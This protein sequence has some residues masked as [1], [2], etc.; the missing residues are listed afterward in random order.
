MYII[1]L[2]YVWGC[3]A[4]HWVKLLEGTNHFVQPIFLVKPHSYS[5]T[6]TSPLRLPMFTSF[7]LNYLLFT[8]MKIIKR[9]QLYKRSSNL[10]HLL[11]N[12][13][14]SNDFL[15]DLRILLIISQTKSPR[16]VAVSCCVV[17]P[18]LRSLGPWVPGPRSWVAPPN[19]DWP[20]P[21]TQKPRI[22]GFG[23]EKNMFQMRTSW[24]L[25][26]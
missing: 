15:C 23:V 11:F 2:L 22:S 14:E 3:A 16:T 26:Y 24:M 21:G 6:A 4:F 9:I 8:V 12:F 1:V 25:E 7:S 10:H 18:Q 13:P 17:L 19:V 20:P 5:L